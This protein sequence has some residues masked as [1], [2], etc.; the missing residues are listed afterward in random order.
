MVSF[1]G[2]FE[3]KHHLCMLMEYVEGGDCASLL[4][5]VGVLPIEVA[6]LYIAET[7]LAIEVCAAFLQLS[8]F[9]GFFSI[10]M[11]AVSCIV[12]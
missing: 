8:T 9:D 7:L 12:T 1:Y 11:I 10:F 5:S 2:S 4:K 6:R 3:T